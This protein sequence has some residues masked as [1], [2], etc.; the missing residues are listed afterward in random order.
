MVPKTTKGEEPMTRKYENHTEPVESIQSHCIETLGLTSSQYESCIER[1]REAGMR[2]RDDYG[3]QG[4]RIFISPAD[5]ESIVLD[6]HLT[7]AGK[8]R[9]EIFGGEKTD[10]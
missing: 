2:W 8:E 3:S 10:D 7:L 6:A 4:H 1:A 9:L 5:A